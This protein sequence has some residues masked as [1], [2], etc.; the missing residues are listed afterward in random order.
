ML[1]GKANPGFCTICERRTLFVEHSP[2]LRDDYRCIRCGSIPR[3]R[4]LILTLDREFPQWRSMRV[5][6]ASPGGKAA[7]KI[8]T[9]P[10]YSCGAYPAEDLEALPHPDAS[11]DLVI[12][13]DVLEHVQR[14][15]LAFAEIARVLRP[16]G[17]HVFT[18]PVLRG[19]ETVARVGESGDQL[20]PPLYHGPHIVVTD[21]G[22]DLPSF[23]AEHSGLATQAF[24]YH[25]RH[26]GL[27]GE[28]LEV[29]VTRAPA[30]RS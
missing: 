10:G 26:F 28:L 17:A 11:F 8:A 7:P 20:L 12:T 9:V 13:Q 18:V 15:A 25:D 27:D 19:T 5:H 3:E 1:N 30:T 14:P 23:V 16:G 21:W 4:A 22:D 6:E 29:F 2:W 24:P